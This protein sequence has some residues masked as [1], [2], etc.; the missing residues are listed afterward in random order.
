MELIPFFILIFVS[1][2]FS[3]IFMKFHLPWVLALIAA[4]IAIGPHGFELLDM[5]PTLEF[6]GEIGL[7]FLMFMAGLETKLSSFK[8]FRKDIIYLSVLSGVIP[9]G[10]GF[11]IG[12]GLEFGLIASL[13]IGTIF[14][15]SSIAVIV[16]TLEGCELL[17]TKLGKVIVSSTVIVDIASLVMLSVILQNIA[18]TTHLPLP[19]FYIL[20]LFVLIVLRYALPRLRSLIPERSDERDLFQSEVRIVFAMMLGT[21]VIFEALGLHPIVAGFFAGLILSDTMTSEILIEK[22][23]TISYG[24]FIPTFFIIIGAQTDISMLGEGGAQL[25][26]VV[27][28]VLGSFLAKFISGVLGARLIGFKGNDILTVGFATVPQL[29]T[30]LAVVFSAVEYDLLSSELAVSMV[31]LSMVST[32]ISPIAVRKI[33]C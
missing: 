3:A 15:S 20:L 8:Q 7:V 12:Y 9:F 11:F 10:I 32:V 30:T 6:M 22:L 27:I 28:V 31:V 29:S 26:L 5:N 13:L 23:R 4:G 21:V 19:S 17:K 18:P 33:S 24:I 16:P 14:M 25:A 2:I 1:V